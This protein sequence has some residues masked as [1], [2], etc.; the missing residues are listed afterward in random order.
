MTGRARME[1]PHKNTRKGNI[2]NL[3]ENVNEM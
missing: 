2:W 3:V 1:D